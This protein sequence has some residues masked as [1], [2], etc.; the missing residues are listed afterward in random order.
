L[1]LLV[2]DRT[3]TDDHEEAKHSSSLPFALCCGS[4]RRLVWEDVGEEVGRELE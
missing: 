2:N 1:K 4:A 3:E